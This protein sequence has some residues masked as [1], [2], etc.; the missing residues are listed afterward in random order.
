MKNLISSVIY[1]SMLILMVN[2]SYANDLAMKS[3]NSRFIGYETNP[4]N[5]VDLGYQGYFKDS[6]IPSAGLF[7]HQVNTGKITAQKLVQIGIDNGRL[8]ADKINDD[9]YINSVASYLRQLNQIH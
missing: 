9:S 5:L 2:P 8:S 1:T 3:Q 6:G 7:L 4:H